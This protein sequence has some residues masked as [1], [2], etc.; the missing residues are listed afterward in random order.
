MFQLGPKYRHLYTLSEI[1]LLPEA[2]PFCWTGDWTFARMTAVA[3][4]V[5]GT[6]H[7]VSAFS[8][9]LVIWAPSIGSLWRTPQEKLQ[10]NPQSQHWSYAAAGGTLDWRGSSRSLPTGSKCCAGSFNTRNRATV[11]VSTALAL[12]L[13]AQSNRA[14]ASQHHVATA[15]APQLQLDPYE[16]RSLAFRMKVS[17]LTNQPAAK[18]LLTELMVDV[19]NVKQGVF[20]ETTLQFWRSRE[21]VYSKLAPVALDLISAPAS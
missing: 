15:R 6:H 5:F 14:T 2:C 9:H 11:E 21:A 10:R 19:S 12:N 16:Y 13:A 8:L 1:W 7:H 20:N 3:A 18:S 17:M 4:P